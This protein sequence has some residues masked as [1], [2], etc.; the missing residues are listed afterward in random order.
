MSLR[1]NINDPLSLSLKATSKISLM[2]SLSAS[3]LE[4]LSNRREL[5]AQEECHYYNY[6]LNANV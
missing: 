1:N 2:A 6:L 5:A 4:E 3:S